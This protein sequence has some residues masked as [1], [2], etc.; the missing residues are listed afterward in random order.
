MI[1][2]RDSIPTVRPAA[3]SLL[4]VVL[5]CF[6]QIGC[7]QRASIATPKSD[8]FSPISVRLHPVFTKVSHW[9][10]TPAADG[11]DVFVELTDAFG[12]Q[13]KAAG[14]FV[15]D[16]YSY[17]PRSPD[18]RGSRAFQPWLAPVVSIEQQREHY[19][20]TSRAYRFQLIAT[21]VRLDRPYVLG[22][23]F[24]PTGGTGRVFGQLILQQS[25]G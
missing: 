10:N 16:L 24:T 8:M 19:D 22:V 25:G 6:A 5:I 13:T 9:E 4:L 3:E 21:G 18:A 7:G 14:S 17:D 23:S 20:R 15:F 11:L 12:D 1:R 2:L